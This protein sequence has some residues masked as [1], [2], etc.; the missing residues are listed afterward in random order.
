MIACVWQFVAERKTELH[1]ESLT[2]RGVGHVCLVHRYFTTRGGIEYTPPRCFIL[3]VRVGV[4]LH[5][6]LHALAPREPREGVTVFVCNGIVGCISTRVPQWWA[7][8]MSP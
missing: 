2:G 3:E 5:P 6:G 1:P 7:A 4:K 8:A